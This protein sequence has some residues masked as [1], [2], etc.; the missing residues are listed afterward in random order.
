LLYEH[1]NTITDTRGAAC[2]FLG[3]QGKKKSACFTSTK[4]RITDPW[5]AAF[6]VLGIQGKIPKDYASEECRKFLDDLC[7]QKEKELGEILWSSLYLLSEYK[8]VYLLS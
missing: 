2:Q 6:Q 3:I 7:A 1:K 4:V 5:G 8:S